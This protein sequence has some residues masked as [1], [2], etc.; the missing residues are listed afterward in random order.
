MIQYRKL[1][2]DSLIRIPEVSCFLWR[3]QFHNCQ[4]N[5][6]VYTQ[7]LKNLFLRMFRMNI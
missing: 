3:S 1:T 7:I 2:Q 6:F 4:A 5:V